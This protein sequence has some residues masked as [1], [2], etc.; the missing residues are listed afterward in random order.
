LPAGPHTAPPAPAFY[1]ISRATRATR[2]H[3]EGRAR[4]SS[5]GVYLYS[6]MGRTTLGRCLATQPSRAPWRASRTPARYSHAATLASIRLRATTPGATRGL[7]GSPRTFS[8]A[9]SAYAAVYR[10]YACRHAAT[11]RRADTTAW[12]PKPRT[13][14]EWKTTF[15]RDLWTWRYARLRSHF[16]HCRYHHRLPSGSLAFWRAYLRTGHAPHTSSGSMSPPDAWRAPPL[17]PS[18]EQGA[19]SSL[20]APPPLLLPGYASA[21]LPPRRQQMAPVENWLT[22]FLLCTWDL[23]ATCRTHTPLYHAIL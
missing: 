3:D 9:R 13:A 18:C 14:L 22:L 10:D 17:L 4:N 5:I 15:W 20:S 16:G 8:T 21:K 6:T 23:P 1:R 11:A 2:T 7:P 12:L 19:T